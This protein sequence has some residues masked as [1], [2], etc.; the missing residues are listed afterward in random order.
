L[1]RDRHSA[2]A[3]SWRTGDRRAGRH[4]AGQLTAREQAEPFEHGLAVAADEF[5]ADPVPRIAPGL[6]DGHRHA[7]LAQ[8]DAQR[9]SRQSAANDGDG[10]GQ[11]HGVNPMLRC[12]LMG[13]TGP[14]GKD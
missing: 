4:R 12:L 5:A 6:P 8:A 13:G 1:W 11:S 14:P 9:Q 7:A 3:G 10:F 2:G